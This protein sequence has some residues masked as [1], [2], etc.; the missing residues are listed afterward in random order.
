MVGAIGISAMYF[1][2][3]V[4]DVEKAQTNDI[5][6]KT[7]LQT[8]TAGIAAVNVAIATQTNDQRYRTELL[9]ESLKEIRGLIERENVTVRELERRVIKLEQGCCGLV[10]REQGRK[11]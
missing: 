1:Q 2:S 3:L 5:Y 9:T 6:T 7:E 11:Q 8:L 4:Q 10:N